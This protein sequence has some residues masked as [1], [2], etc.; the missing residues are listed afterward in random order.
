MNNEIT[1]RRRP[2]AR[3]PGRCRAN[4]YGRV[5]CVALE[6]GEPLARTHVA[7]LVAQMIYGA[8]I[9]TDAG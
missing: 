7:R 9:E 4:R 3:L 6:S 8:M 5:Y 2:L 1:P